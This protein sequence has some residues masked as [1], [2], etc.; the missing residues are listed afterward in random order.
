VNG[1][2]PEILNIINRKI[3][4]NGINLIHEEKFEEE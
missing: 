1:A 2:N 3:S 4:F